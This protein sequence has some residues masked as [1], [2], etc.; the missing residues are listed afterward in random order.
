MSEKPLEG[1]IA[2]V[3]GGARR[4]GRAVALALGGAGASVAVHYRTSEAEAARAVEEIQA[5]GS[6]AAAFRADLRNVAEIKSLVQDVE[7]RL[8]PIDILI[9]SAAVFGRVVWNEITEE[10]WDNFLNTNLKA[11]VFCAQAA[12]GGMK[13]RG[14]G[15]IV[16][17]GSAG[18]IEVW[19]SHIPYSVAKAGLHHMTRLLARALAPEVRVNAIAPGTIAFRGDKEGEA[20]EAR[21]FAAKA[22]LRRAGEGRD[23]AEAALFL[24]TSAD[25]IT[26]QVLVVDGGHSLV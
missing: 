19:P 2:L 3:T 13:E 9:N 7:E 16:N 8:A 26:G 15:V 18:G 25:F 23:I 21:K 5:A 14:G 4:V 22:P 10:D 20:E 6:Q 12:A 1:K 24:C 17:I 11:Q